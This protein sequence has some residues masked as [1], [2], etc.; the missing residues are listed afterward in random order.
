MRALRWALAL[1][2]M[3]LLAYLSLGRDYPPPIEGALRVTGTALLH[4]GGYG[5][6]AGALARAL[7]GRRQ[8]LPA[9]AGL[10]FAYGAALEA[11]QLLVPG[12]TAAWADLGLNLAGAVAGALILVLGARIACWARRGT[13]GGDNPGLEKE[14]TWN[15]SR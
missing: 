14:G 7:G 15:S 4:F 11:L 1:A 12:R 6:L 5:V 8:R 2:W 10:A 9:G 3:G 13:G